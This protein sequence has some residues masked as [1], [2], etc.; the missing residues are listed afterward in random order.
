MNNIVGGYLHMIDK[1]DVND[2]NI[3]N[4]NLVYSC[5]QLSQLIE[6]EVIYS[7]QRFMK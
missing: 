3:D 6:E 1:N 7:L 5:E 2:E 4:I